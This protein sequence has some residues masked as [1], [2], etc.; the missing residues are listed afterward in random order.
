VLDFRPVALVNGILLATLGAAMLLPALV[1]HSLGNPDWPVFASASGVSVFV[2]LSM[3]LASRGAGRRLGVREAFLMTTLAWVLLGVFAALPFVWSELSLSFTDAFFEA[4]SGLTTTGA[5]TIV[6]LDHAPPGILLWRG[7]LQWLGGLGIIV[8][9]IAV[10]PMLQ[11]GGMQLFKIEAFEASEKILPRATQISGSLTGL[12]ILFTLVNAIAYHL[13][14]MDVLDAAIHAMTTIATGGF[15]SHDASMGYFD[16]TAIETIAIVFMI[17]GG[18]PFL[19]FIKAAQGRPRSLLTDSQVRMFLAFIAIFS[20]LALLAQTQSEHGV[21]HGLR[22]AVFNIVSTMT[23]TGY[24]TVDYGLWGPFAV[25]LF[26]CVM[27]VGGCAGSTSCGIKVFRFQV[28][29]QNISQHLKQVLHPHG[30]F[31]NLYNGKPLPDNVSASVMSF[32]FLYFL[33]V[34]V[35]AVLLSIQGLDLVTALSAAATTVS[36]VGPGLGPTIGPAGTFA[37]LPD[38]SKWTLSFA[39]LVGRLELFTVL[40]L[41]T[42]LFWR[43]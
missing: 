36:N 39:M 43:Q 21:E 26:F 30:V 12:Y 17:V 3:V 31:V 9:A 24:T 25:A 33:V 32:F 34:G 41:L 5:T 14:G 40:V 2:G 27:F 37:P 1:D 15:S 10:M 35:V 7:L 18:M 28:L 13:A 42:P 19:L 11:V 20:A 38:V 16:S 22:E 8:M 6:G 29:Y 4:I 23:G